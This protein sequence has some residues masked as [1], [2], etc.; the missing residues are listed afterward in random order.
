[1]A[2]T[3]PIS[4]CFQPILVWRTRAKKWKQRKG[5]TNTKVALELGEAMKSRRERRGRPA[6]KGGE[7][8]SR[9]TFWERIKIKQGIPQ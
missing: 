1:M 7:Q 5:D 6:K 4:P 9:S 8:A 3:T 2:R